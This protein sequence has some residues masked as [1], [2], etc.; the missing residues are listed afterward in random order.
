MAQTAAI[1]FFDIGKTASISSNLT[2]ENCTE[3]TS[4]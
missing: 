3:R 4:E 1:L 2:A